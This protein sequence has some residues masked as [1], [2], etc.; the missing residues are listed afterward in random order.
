MKM[1]GLCLGQAPKCDGLKSA[2]HATKKN[3]KRTTFNLILAYDSIYMV[4][5]SAITY[6][7]YSTVYLNQDF[8]HHGPSLL[9]LHINYHNCTY[10]LNVEIL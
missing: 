6:I 3:K 10:I 9:E 1:S 4:M 7:Y 8:F 2:M 5:N